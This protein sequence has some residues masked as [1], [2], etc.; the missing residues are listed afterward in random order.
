MEIPTESLALAP[1]AHAVPVIA[2]TS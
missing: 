2:S 1:S